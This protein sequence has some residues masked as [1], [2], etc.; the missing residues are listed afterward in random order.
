MTVLATDALSAV[1]LRPIRD[2]DV[3]RL[4]RLFFRLSTTTVHRRFFAGYARP[5]EPA[6]HR[7]AEV[8]HWHREAVVAAVGDEVVG[9]ARFDR[10]PGTT[11]AEPAIVVED[12]WQG[13]GVGRLLAERLFAEA[14]R[15]G[16][17]E[18]R[19]SILA[20]NRAPLRLLRALSPEVQVSLN[21]TEY[22]V[23]ATV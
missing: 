20:E 9:V 10:L 15:R 19:A 21:G 16:V 8:D 14:A 23:V 17:T 11:A 5:P 7:L 6:L 18:F 4:R 12:A 3:D 22:D 1:V 13:R 2:D